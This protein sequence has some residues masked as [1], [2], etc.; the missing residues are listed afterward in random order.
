VNP[1]PSS[2][3]IGAGLVF[4]MSSALLLTGAGCLRSGTYVP[5]MYYTVDPVIEAPPA[6][7]CEST[8]GIRTLTSARPYNKTRM[9]YREEG[10]VIGEYEYDEWAELPTAFVTRAL[11]DTLISSNRYEDTGYAND[12]PSPDFILTGQLRQFVELRTTNPWT[13]VCEVRIEVRDTHEGSVVWSGTPSASVPIHDEGPSAFAEAM[14][15]AVGQV[16]KEAVA[17]I[18][19]S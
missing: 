1:S 18:V 7:S 12:M 10:L 6:S 19:S 8:L 3:R 17:N 13:A 4:G 5:T 16:V 15:K 11:L 2:R 9:H 14:S